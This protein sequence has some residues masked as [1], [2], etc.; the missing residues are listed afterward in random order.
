MITWCKDIYIH[1]NSSIFNIL[2]LTHT[3]LM[4]NVN[5]RLLRRGNKANLIIECYASSS[6]R[7]SPERLPVRKAVANDSFKLERHFDEI[8][9]Q[10]PMGELGSRKMVKHL[11]ILDF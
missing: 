6:N 2:P 11:S 3:P 9:C 1:L 5:T 4:L 7:C 8:A 10:Q